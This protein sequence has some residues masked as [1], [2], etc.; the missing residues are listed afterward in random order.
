MKIETSN[1]KASTKGDDFKLTLK[2]ILMGSKK[3][4]NNNI[5]KMKI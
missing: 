4:C 5:I 1:N 3:K 2:D